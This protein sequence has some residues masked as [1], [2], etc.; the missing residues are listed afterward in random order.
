MKKLAI[1][2]LL[3]FFVFSEKSI[4]CTTAVISGKA[5]PDG[6]SMIWKLRDTDDLENS[7]RYF[8]DG[9]YSYIG[10]VNSKDIEGKNVWGGSN[11][12]GFA[13]MNSASFNVNQN[14]TAS[15]KD[16]EGVFMK[17][18][19]QICASLADFEKLLNTHPR[20]MGLAAHF[21]VIDTNGGAA[22]YEVNNHTWTKFDANTNP[23]GYVLRT[24][25]SETGTPDV[26]YGFIRRQTAEKIFAEASEKGKLN[27]QTIIQD[28]S[29]C[30][31]HPVFDIDYRKKY[32]AGNYETDF[33]SSDDMIT[34]HGSASN[35]LIQG[36][37]KGESPDM[38]TIWVQVGFPETCI[39]IPLWV[40]GGENLP[41]LVQ[42]DDMIK[43]SP[44]N[45][46]ALEW[47]KSVYPIGRSDGYH[48]LKMTKLINKNNTGYVQRI[49]QMEK[50]VFFL[51]EE[52]LEMWR[53]K[54][55]DPFSISVFYDTLDRKVGDFYAEEDISR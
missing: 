10:L 36:V 43:N 4:S 34:R 28:F 49:E 25:Y 31:Y 46:Y 17:L 50:N 53:K 8:N 51:T 29:R 22:F 11:S 40:R 54:L 18:A 38:N 42:Y 19:L 27:Y 35:I 21:G 24:N 39:T 14:D 12:A 5:T 48:Y 37:K 41:L 26:G 15:L 30:F 45:A 6:R 7:M 13:I 44:L 52:K 23:N 2:L 47:K 16:Q 1:I 9:K 3:T 55:P 33:I 32:E 20:P